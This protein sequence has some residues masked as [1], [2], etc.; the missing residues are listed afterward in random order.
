[1]SDYVQ[2]K[3]WIHTDKVGSQCEDIVEFERKEWEEMDDDQKEANCREVAFAMMDWS[4][5]EVER[6]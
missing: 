1:M 6:A 4:F 2:V 5:E 3:V